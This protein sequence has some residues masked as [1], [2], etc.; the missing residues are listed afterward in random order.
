[1]KEK[2]E[3]YTRKLEGLSTEELSR[4]AEAKTK[5][6]DGGAA[7]NFSGEGEHRGEEAAGG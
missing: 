3:R 4:S 2:I 6:G 7:Q 1:M 5:E